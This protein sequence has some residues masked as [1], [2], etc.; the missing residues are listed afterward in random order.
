MRLPLAQ[1]ANACEVG[2]RIMTGAVAPS[3]KEKEFL[4]E[5]LRAAGETLRWL[6]M[7]ESVVRA[8]IRGQAAERA[9]TT[10][11]AA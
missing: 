4:A 9:T 3:K 2:V 6:E 8:A 1:Q 7:N 11:V 5:R 10:G